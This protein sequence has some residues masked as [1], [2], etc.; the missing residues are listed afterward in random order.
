[1]YIGKIKMGK[2]SSPK[3]FKELENYVAQKI[4]S[5][6]VFVIYGMYSV[7]VEY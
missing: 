5:L 6:E 4:L 1:M 3:L 2:I 7:L